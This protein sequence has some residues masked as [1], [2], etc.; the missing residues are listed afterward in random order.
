[1]TTPVEAVDLSQPRT[2]HLVGIGGAGMSAIATVLLADGHTITGSDRAEGP[3]LERLRGL[4]ASITVGQDPGAA[5]AAELVAR[6]TAVPDEDDDVRGALAGGVPV[7]RRADLLSA[8]TA[9]RRTI[10]VSGTHGKTTTSGML[11]TILVDAGFQPS[12]LIGADV[13]SLDGAAHWGKGELFVVEGDESDGSFEALVSY[14]VAVTNLEPDHLEHHAGFEPLREAFGRF[15]EAADGPRVVDIDEPNAARLAG[16]H[17]V[18]TC[19]QTA[20]AGYELVDVELGAD[21]SS[22][23]ILTGSG[24]TEHR[25]HVDLGVPGAHNVANALTA[26]VLALEL[27]AAPEA[28]SSGLARFTGVTRRFEERGSVAGVRFIDDYAHLPTEVSA[29]VATGRRAT[30]GRLVVVFQPHRYSRTQALA[31][32]FVDSF[33]EADVVA[34]TDVYASSEKA[35]PGITGKLVVDAVLGGHPDTE[36]AWLPTLDDVADWLTS[37]LDPGDLCLT[38][39][40]GDLTHVPDRVIDRLEGAR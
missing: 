4:G 20:G 9:T 16:Q 3:V 8:I 38:L 1:M 11:A 10:T 39:G 21:R 36:L 22:F 32:D 35:R 29:A 17:E 7:L 30:S 13:A 19:G 12:W 37:H 27:G 24:P 15:V 31:P 34:I 28:V 6:S 5:A 18:V 33:I 2:I 25:I 26:A 40:A 14:A 23:A